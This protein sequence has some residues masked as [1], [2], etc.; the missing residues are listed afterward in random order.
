MVV[1]RGSGAAEKVAG[2]H[3][4]RRDAHRLP[5][6]RPTPDRHILPDA[7]LL[8]SLPAAAAADLFLWHFW[9]GTRE[10]VEKAQG[11]QTLQ[12]TLCGYRPADLDSDTQKQWTRHGPHHLGRLPAGVSTEIELDRSLG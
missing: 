1:R 6:H 7:R 9:D 2:S 3:A 10:L 12:R 4:T 5:P 11:W 8:T